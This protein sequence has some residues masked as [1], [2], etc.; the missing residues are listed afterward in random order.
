MAGVKV[1]T[2]AMF[3]VII[4]TMNIAIC[5]PSPDFI[6]PEFALENL[7]HII[8]YTKSNLKETDNLTLLYQTGVRTD[9]NRNLMLKRLLEDDIDWNYVLWLDADMIYPIDIITTYLKEDFDIIG[10]MYFKR[11]YPYAPVAYM[12]G[13]NPLK[14][15]KNVNP[16]E[17]GWGVYRVDGLGYGGMMV[18]MDLYRR[19]GDDK[20]T[21][22]GR[23]FH[24]PYDTEDHLTHDLEFCR[25]AKEKYNAKILL[26]GSV[27]PK[28]I[29][30]IMVDE[31]HWSS[32]NPNVGFTSNWLERNLEVWNKHIK[33]LKPKKILEIGCYEGRSTLWFLENFPE[34]TVEVIDT[35][36]GSGYLP[37]NNLFERF[38]NNT[39]KY[40]DRLI[41]N[42]GKSQDILPK[43][44][45]KYD[46]IYVDGSHKYE[47]VKLDAK[48]S[49]QLLNKGGHIIFDDYLWNRW[50]NDDR[51]KPAIDEFIENTDNIKVV[52]I[53]EQV[54][55]KRR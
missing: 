36:D 42:V 13:D 51:P 53:G 55:V 7:P 4:K 29:G 39:N 1:L 43:L 16:R 5:V 37:A 18:N 31:S 32:V 6:H 10:C 30:K 14:P 50:N 8:S 17:T 9:R 21:N 2:S 48:Y 22:Y 54:I 11:V 33:P 26:H 15:F 45:D 46:L 47:D 23:N 38:K 35:F 19:M 28:H 49:W 40:K 52:H 24:L 41:I 20:W 27:R 44:K 3:F 12:K 25:V 34:A